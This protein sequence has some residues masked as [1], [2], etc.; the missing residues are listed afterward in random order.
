MRGNRATGTRPEMAVRSAVHRLGMR[1]RKHR[2]PV[3]MIRCVADLIFPTERVA[4]FVG[5]CYWHRCPDHGT[6]PRTNSE[7]WDAKLDRN[8]ARDRRNDGA[9]AAAGWTVVRAWEHEPADEVAARI[10]A[11]VRARRGRQPES[12]L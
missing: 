12:E 3:P 2:R 9:L 1:F 4:V 6:R 11:V 5:G 8:V 7:Y 10:A